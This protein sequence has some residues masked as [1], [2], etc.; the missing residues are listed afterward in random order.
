MRLGARATHIDIP[1]AGF[2]FRR[3]RQHRATPA[4]VPKCPLARYFFEAPSRFCLPQ[5]RVSAPDFFCGIFGAC[6]SVP[7]GP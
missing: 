5:T 1:P 6:P 3:R 7:A 2:Y 4:D